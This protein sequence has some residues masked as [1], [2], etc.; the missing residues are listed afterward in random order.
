[1]CS[2]SSC[3]ALSCTG[4]L[5]TLFCG[6]N[7]GLFPNSSSISALMLWLSAAARWLQGSRCAPVSKVGYLQATATGVIFQVPRQAK[8][9]PCFASHCTSCAATVVA[10]V[11]AVTTSYGRCMHSIRLATSLGRAPSFGT[12]CSMAVLPGHDDFCLGAHIASIV[13]MP[14]LLWSCYCLPVLVWP[15]HWDVAAFGSTCDTMAATA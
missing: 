12:E 2:S 13:H 3:A 8:P 5:P 11:C 10:A 9:W 4:H 7:V 1:M 15:N 6:C 14:M